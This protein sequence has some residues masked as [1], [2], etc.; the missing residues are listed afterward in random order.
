[1]FSLIAQFVEMT[2]FLEYIHF[3][4]NLDKNILQVIHRVYW[5]PEMAHNAIAGREMEMKVGDRILRYIA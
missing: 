1:M 4:L 2:L 5:H 3:E